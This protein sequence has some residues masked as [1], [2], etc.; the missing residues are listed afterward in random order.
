MRLPKTPRLL[1]AAAVMLLANACGGT[2]TTVA[3]PTTPRARTAPRS[4]AGGLRRPSEIIADDLAAGGAGRT[5]VVT[6]AHSDLVDAPDETANRFTSTNARLAWRIAGAPVNGFV[7]VLLTPTADSAR[8][9]GGCWADPVVRTLLPVEISAYVSVA[10]L[11]QAL[12]SDVD[13]T[14][15][16]GHRVRALTG[17]VALPNGDSLRLADD[18]LGVEFDAASS[19]ALEYGWSYVC[20]P[21]GCTR[22]ELLGASE[23][24]AC[25]VAPSDGPYA[26]GFARVTGTGAPRTRG[27]EGRVAQL[28]SRCIEVA[29]AL[30]QSSAPLACSG[31]AA[32]NAS[33][34]EPTEQAP[35]Y[36]P[37]NLDFGGASYLRP[38]EPARGRL[39]FAGEPDVSEGLYTEDIR[40]GVTA[41]AESVLACYEEELLMSADLNGFMTLTFSIGPD[42][43]V[44]T[45]HVEDSTI[46]QPSLSSCIETAV[47]GWTFL[48][49]EHGRTVLVH[50]PVILAPP[51]LTIRIRAG[52]ALFNVRGEG[53]GRVLEETSV[54]LDE[55]HSNANRQCFAVPLE[56]PVHAQ[57]PLFVCLPTH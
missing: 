22:R 7:P 10:S 9:P 55:E 51:P 47:R 38:D 14:D 11:E 1:S 8:I 23:R 18:R 2:T 27:A 56:G 44:T 42:G 29:Y 41:H 35:R 6:A 13:R 53:I 39:R 34:D 46:E 54:G 49:P 16:S 36:Y 31:P 48:A 3:T 32:P 37:A 17:T 26:L 40:D 52:T 4:T 19:A 50:Y 33:A 24:R 20:P 15:A 57:T 28:S 43:H 30:P 21:R 5:Y 25:P 12:R 45:A